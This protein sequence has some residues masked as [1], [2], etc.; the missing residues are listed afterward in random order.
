MFRSLLLLSFAAL[1][2]NACLPIPPAPPTTTPT[3]MNTA[4]FFPSETPSLTPYSTETTLPSF[5]PSPTLTETGTAT[6]ISTSTS[7]VTTNPPTSPVP[8]T[9]PSLDDWDAG[10]LAFSH[11]AEGEWDYILWGGFANSLIRKGNTY[12]LYY[13]GSSSTTTNANLFPNAPLALPPAQMA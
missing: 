13:Q 3:G 2:S 7:T 10:R 11:G 6:P 12:Y 5:T 1:V 4:T 9:F 8:L